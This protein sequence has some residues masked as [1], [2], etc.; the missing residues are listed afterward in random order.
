MLVLEIAAGVFLGLVLYE[1]LVGSK[2][3]AAQK[4]EDDAVSAWSRQLSSELPPNPPNKYTGH[5]HGCLCKLCVSVADIDHEDRKIQLQA[6]MQKQ[7][8]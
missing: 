7:K 2:L 3:R 6:E 1:W 5:A 8:V 4:D